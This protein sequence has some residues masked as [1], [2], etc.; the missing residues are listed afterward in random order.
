MDYSNRLKGSI[1]QTLLKSLLTDVG[2]KVVP[3]GVEEIIRE[4]STLNH[5]DYNNLNLPDV[6]RKMPDFF[7]SNGDLS[8]CWL[9]EV[10]FRK[11]WDENVKHALGNGLKKQVESW[12]DI[13]VIILL[14]KSAPDKSSEIPSAWIGVAK[15][16]LNNNI[17]CV[18]TEDGTTVTWDDLKWVNLQRIQKIFTELDSATK[19]SEAILMKTLS[20]NKYLIT[21]N[22]LN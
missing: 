11:K 18:S 9:V 19:W 16:F 21:D 20:I 10:K 22:V 6:L 7:V 4:V 8:Q 5:N 2:Y 12:G 14:G 13:Y 15:V 3:L 17:L 1:T